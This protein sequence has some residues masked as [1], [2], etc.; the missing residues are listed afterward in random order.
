M[1]VNPNI[2]LQIRSPQ[3]ANP[4][5]IVAGLQRIRQGEQEQ[6][7]NAMRMEQAQRQQ[8]AQERDM[9]TETQAQQIAKQI[10]AGDTS[11]FAQAPPEVQSKL[12][13]WYQGRQDRLKK[14]RQ[15]NANLIKAFGY[16]LTATEAIFHLDDSP[17]AAAL[18]Q[19]YRD[20]PE[21][22]RKI[23]DA[24]A[25]PD[26]AAPNLVQ[27]DPTKDIANPKTGEVVRAGVPAT[28]KLTY[29]AP[30]AAMVNGKRVFV[31]TGSD[32]RTYTMSGKPIDIEP[33]PIPPESGGGSPYFVPVQTG[34]GI[35]PFNT[36]TGNYVEPN[37]KDLRPSASAE[38]D[39][40][41]VQS[42]LYQVKEIRNLFTPE[43]VGPLKGRY[44]TMQ[45]ALVGELGEEGLAD[46]QSAT[47]T[48]GN[49]VINLRTGAQMSEPE[50]QRILKEIPN[51]N[52]PPD[53]YLARL[54][55][56]EDYFQEWYR[57]RAKLAFGRTTKEDVDKM[58]APKVGTEQ[59]G[60]TKEIPGY[61]GT[62]QT[63]KN[64]KWIRT[65]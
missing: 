64:G 45:L 57:N 4:L 63:F 49:T 33:V 21:I 20:Q 50:A 31:R 28:E 38:V 15:E 34:E 54:G 39:L 56:A 6:Q 51:M 32:G 17:E 19:K 23:V 10:R 12:E 24:F 29:G 18:F 62:E 8:A 7:I 30:T 25:E 37:R 48:L 1:P 55:R 43:R 35:I 60:A 41:R 5:D 40:T 13:A 11:V 2:P 27:F 47:A 36:R 26:A 44:K 46:F 59:E 52:L 58:V 61:P 3:I 42:T 22:L 53:V 65:K 16:D 9:Q 14:D